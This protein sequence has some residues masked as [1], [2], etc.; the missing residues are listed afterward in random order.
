MLRILAI[1]GNQ[2]RHRYLVEKLQE[3]GFL[4]GWISEEREA[5]IPE[6]PAELS[7]NLQRLFVRHFENRLNSE[8]RFFSPKSEIAV[9]NP[10]ITQADLNS[11]ETVDLI[12]SLSPDLVISYGCHK[13]SDDLMSSCNTI[14]WNTH[15]GLSPDYRGVITHFWP[16]YNLEPQ[17]TGMTLHQTTSQIDG[18]RIFHQSAASLV[19][20]DGIHELAARAV[21]NYGEAL[22]KM[23]ETIS[24]DGFPE[25]EIQ[26]F[27]GRIYRNSDWR[28]EHLSLIYEQFEDKIV[29]LTLSG[30]LVGRNPSLISVF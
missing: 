6:V 30:D 25:G 16:S 8:R 5:F 2:P 12:N 21:L 1:T 7:A 26:N 15:G 27:S 24:R 9:P 22:P 20:G 19:P 14:F 23:L 17:M 3:S 18:G 4:V 11:R 13:L 29:D 10:V 28:P